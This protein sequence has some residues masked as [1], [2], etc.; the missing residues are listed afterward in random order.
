M[1]S[2]IYLDHAATTPLRPEVRAAM[3]PYLGPDDFGNPSSQHQHGQRARRALDRA[4]DTFASS[5]DCEAS[6]ITFTS[7]GTEADNMALFG[8]MQAN[9]QRGNHFIT[10]L[11]EHDAV[12]NT[13]KFLEGLGFDVTYVAPNS[14]GQIDPS[15]IEA[16]ITPATTLISVMTANNEMGAIQPVGEIGAIARR[17]GIVFHTDAVQAFGQIPVSPEELNADLISFS[18]HKIYGP[19]G[20]GALYVRT[21]VSIESFLHGGGQ[22][23]DRRSG[24]E[25][26][27][28]IVGFAEA[29]ELAVRE[30]EQNSERLTKLRAFFLQTLRGKIP[31]TVMNGPSANRLP[32]NV[33]I[34]FAD[35]DAEAIL[36]S[37][38]L[39]RI[40][41]SS[42]SAC[43][44]GSI[45][46]SHVLTAMGLPNERVLSAIRFSLGRKTTEE[47]IA[48]TV[49]VLTEIT[50]RMRQI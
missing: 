7:G 6:E 48:R 2:S 29:A 31:D 16:A 43:S 42:G 14:E 10:T 26:V 50:Q 27:A 20:T 5:I 49:D 45:E 8:I 4:R 21:G 36:L 30:R 39:H 24:T 35:L 47:E 32:N 12:L 18:A 33:N 9:R 38:D 19:K 23:R 25:N 17:H 15:H 40:S 11:I 13:A 3:E 46:P 1:T 28:G 44:S 22:E 37:L 34:S 41:A